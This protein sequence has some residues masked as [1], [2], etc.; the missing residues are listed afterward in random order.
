MSLLNK[1]LHFFMVV[2][3][4]YEI[5]AMRKLRED[6]NYDYYGNYIGEEN[7]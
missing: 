5:E 3:G 2:T 1:I 6:P 4:H 7:E